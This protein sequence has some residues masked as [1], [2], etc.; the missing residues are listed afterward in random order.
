[1]LS[2]ALAILSMGDSVWP[3]TLVDRLAVFARRPPAAFRW[4]RTL[5]VAVAGFILV[6]SATQMV[7]RTARF[8]RWPVALRAMVGAVAP[9]HLVNA[10][11]LFAVMTTQRREII[12]EGSNDGMVWT[13]Y[14]FRYKPDDVRKRPEFVA[15]HQPRLDWQM[16]FAA[17]S[18][19]RGQRWFLAFCARLLEG[20]PTVLSLLKSNPFP[21]APPRY[22]RATAYDYRFSSPAER[23][24]GVWWT[25]TEIGQ[26]CPPLSLRRDQ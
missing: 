25:R 22:I 21:N 15:P 23:R 9:F 20:S 19:V 2:M 16:W 13:P 24:A 3:R 17:L 6:V 1:M 18:D 8:E 7:A 12:V 4:P 5:M 10:Y 14:Q 11:G 26:Y